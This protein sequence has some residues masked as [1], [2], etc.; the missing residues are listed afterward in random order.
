L[1]YIVYAV[2]NNNTEIV[3]DCAEPNDPSKSNNDYYQEFLDKLPSEDCRYAVFDFEYEKSDG[4]GRRNRICFIAWSPDKARIKPKLLY[5]TSREALTRR[6]VGI[7]VD[8]KAIEKSEVSLETV[9]EKC[10]KY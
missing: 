1:K 6:L 4:S 5:S 7:Q 2:G 8:V 3:V 9:E 10:N